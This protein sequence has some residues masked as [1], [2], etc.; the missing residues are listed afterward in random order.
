MKKFLRKVLALTT[1]AT[2][3]PVRITHDDETGK[4]T[5][6]SL[7]AT[8]TLGPGSDGVTT[9]ASINMGEGVL[10]EAIQ[11]M[12]VARQEAA[13][14]ADEELIITPVEAEPTET[15]QAE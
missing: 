7:L 10:T 11:G 14:F 4:T 8:L 15:T 6:Q 9:D 5:Y 1:L 12:I 2:V 3:V 13:M